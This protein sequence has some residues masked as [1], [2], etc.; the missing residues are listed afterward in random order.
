MG[1]KGFEYEENAYDA[2]NLQK[3]T[4]GLDI[5]TGGTAGASADKP[6]LTIQRK[7]IQGP[8]AGGKGHGVE[9]K[10]SPTAAGSLVMKYVVSRRAGKKGE[11]V[12]GSIN[13]SGD[14]DVVHAEKAFIRGMGDLGF[15]KV[16]GGEGLLKEMNSSG[17]RGK[18][19]R[20]HVPAL[21]VN[22]DGS[23]C[24][25]PGCDNVRDA[26]NLDIKHFGGQNEIK[27]PLGG[28][29]AISEYYNTKKCYYINVG[30]HG[31]FLLGNRDPLKLNKAMRDLGYSKAIPDFGASAKCMIRVRVHDKSR[32]GPSGGSFFE[33]AEDRVGGYQFTMTFQFSNVTKSPYNIAPLVAGSK[34]K[35]DLK[36]LK[37]DKLLCAWL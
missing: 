23:K 34:S 14:G 9:L 20:L 16:G 10:I 26:Y 5:S 2:L 19:W 12:Y 27:I 13:K 36:H 32:S 21:R 25:G 17:N 35:I 3:G 1:Q 4:L 29:S 6:D 18:Q 11:W 37:A 31:F 7:G 30:T 24:F 28:A 22:P 33:G 8:W 15:G